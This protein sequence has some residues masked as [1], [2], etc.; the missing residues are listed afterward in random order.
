MT[1]E[2][3]MYSSQCILIRKKV[4]FGA[5]WGWGGTY[6]IISTG[7]R[8]A[9]KRIAFHDLCTNRG[10]EVWFKE[11]YRFLDHLYLSTLI[12]TLLFLLSFL[13]LVMFYS[14]R[15]I[16]TYLSIKCNERVDICLYNFGYTFSGFW[17][18]IGKPL[19]DGTSLS[20]IK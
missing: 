2:F 5:R 9:Q 6:F 20:V 11:G 1:T 10:L 19:L 8:A 4:M 18:M 13:S 7:G 14:K 12:A 3:S 15:H 16:I 17:H